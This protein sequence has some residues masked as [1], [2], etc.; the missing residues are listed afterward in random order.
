MPHFNA[1][2]YPRTSIHMLIE[3]IVEFS[4][5]FRE[6]V[7]STSSFTTLAATLEQILASPM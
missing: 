4:C 6:A 3:L 2:R 5:Y 1:P 7:T